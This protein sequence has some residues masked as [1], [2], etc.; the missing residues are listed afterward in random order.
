MAPADVQGE[1]TNS[2][3]GQDSERESHSCLTLPLQMFQIC[4]WKMKESVVLRA[5]FPFIIH[6]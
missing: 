1:L 3:G 5:V 6:P 2:W 4:P